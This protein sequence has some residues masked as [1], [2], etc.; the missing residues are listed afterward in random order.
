MRSDPENIGT[1]GDIIKIVEGKFDFHQRP[2]LDQRHLFCNGDWYDWTEKV[3]DINGNV[4]T[5]MVDNKPED[6]SVHD[7][8]DFKGMD[9]SGQEIPKGLSQKSG[10]GC[11]WDI[12]SLP[13]LLQPKIKSDLL[14][15][16]SDICVLDSRLQTIFLLAQK[17]PRI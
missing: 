16:R 15:S 6:K 7:D 4:Q 14:S 9:F 17:V 2:N 12:K 3:Y 5:K 13:R 8:N 11:K 1:I 10:R